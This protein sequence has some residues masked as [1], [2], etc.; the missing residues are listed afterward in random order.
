M[1]ILITGGNGFIGAWIAKRLAARG[2]ALRIFDVAEN[3]R[4]LAAIAG[5]D[6]ATKAEWR[7]G[8]IV[9][10]DDVHAAAAGCDGIIHLAGVLTDYCT[11]NPIRGAEVNLIG[12]LNVFEAARAHGIARIVYTSSAGVYGPEPDAPVR[13]ITHYGAF[14]LACEG[15]ARAYWADHK[16]ASVGFRPFIVYGPGRESGLTSGPALACRAAARGE[17]YVIPYQGEAGLVYVE[18]IAAA[19]ES[20]LLR[21]PDGAQVVNMPGEIAS[22]ADVVAEIKK[23]V[24]HADIHIDGPNLPFARDVGEGDLR[25]VLP[26]APFT[27]LADGIAKTIA[28][29]RQRNDL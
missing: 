7:V 10:G 1:R 27:S 12:T 14:K 21:T 20:A 4:L 17:R 24:P 22:N 5:D 2:F 16:L 9:R 15:S 19:Y 8:D 23:H 11:T 6:V 28:F 18:D 13:P 25:K 29:Y 26:D 3:R